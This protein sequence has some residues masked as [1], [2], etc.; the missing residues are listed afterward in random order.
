[1]PK[2]QVIL[3][4]SSLFILLIVILLFKA[5]STYSA[6]ATHVVISEIQ[7]GGGVAD[8]E[9]VELYNPTTSSVD[10]SGWR[11]TRKT[12]AGTTENNLVASLS[13]SIPAHGYFLVAH[14]D[15]DGAVAEDMVY[16]ATSS[17]IAANN[18]VVLYSDAGVTV[19]DKV[20][21][22]TATDVE[23]TATTSPDADT[24]IERKANSS[25]TSDSMGTSG[26]DETAGN[27]EDTDVNSSDFVGRTTSDPQN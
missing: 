22:G 5:K 14:P 3:L 10:L 13:G 15:Y 20:G 17:A 4:F 7:V 25:S 2:K 21:M 19:V 24:S 12:A 9:F 6:L 1:M 8:D 16:S 26:V 18:S 23:T 11:L 27:G